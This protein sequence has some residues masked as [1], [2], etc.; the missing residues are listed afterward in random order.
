MSAPIH[1]LKKSEIVK[2]SKTH[3]AAHAH[4]YLEHYACYL[5]EHPEEKERVGFWDIEASNL[6]ADYGIMLSWAIKDANSDTIYYDV[7]TP[8]DAKG[9]SEDKRLVKSC[10]EHLGKFDK[11]VTYFGTG[12]DF[13]FT[14]ARALINGL[15]FPGYGT[16][17]HKDLYYVI[18]NKFK[19]SSRR[20]ENACKQLLGESE[21]TK[22]DAKFWRDG[23][24]G[25]KKS[26][27]YIVDHNIKDVTDLEKLYNKTIEFSKLNNNSI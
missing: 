5:K 20:L 27:Q 6:V 26:L 15:D 11:I 1:R 16:L 2:L 10:I 4:N 24:R 19:L 3:C 13:P 9:G 21:K 23:V 14:R 12:Y 22:I 7:L 25:D 8:A 17:V 18:R